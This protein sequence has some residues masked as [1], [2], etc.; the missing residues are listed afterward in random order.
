[1]SGTVYQG[2]GESRQPVRGARVY[3]DARPQV[4]FPGASI[5]TDQGGRYLLCGL[6]DDQ[7]LVFWAMFEGRAKAELV[8]PGRSTRDFVF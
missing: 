1:V 2:T 4:D 8:N 6:P 7:Q 3:Y 5:V